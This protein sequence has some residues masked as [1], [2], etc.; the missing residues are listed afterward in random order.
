MTRWSEPI[1]LPPSR[2]GSSST[3][4]GLVFGLGDERD[5]TP[6][7]R[8]TGENA[9]RGG[10]TK[11]GVEKF[12][13]R[14]DRLDDILVMAVMPYFRNPLRPTSQSP[15]ACVRLGLQADIHG[16]EVD[17]RGREAGCPAPPAQIPACAANAPGS[18]LGFWRRSGDRVRDA[19]SGSAE[20]NGW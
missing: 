8:S 20:R 10:I 3:A 5:L 1:R 4:F 17:C 9:K 7:E 14:P 13:V 18:S 15:A 19:I 6:S 12:A 11:A 16:S 2:G